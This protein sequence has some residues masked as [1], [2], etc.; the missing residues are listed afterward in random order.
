MKRKISLSTRALAFAFALVFALH[1]ANFSARAAA[2]ATSAAN[3]PFNALPASD[4]VVFIDI[5]QILTSA[6]PGLLSS[7]PALIDKMRAELNKAATESGVDPNK[8]EYAVFGVRMP[9]AGQ[10]QDPSFVALVRGSF[11]ASDVIAAGFKSAKTPVSKQEQTYQGKTI[12]IIRETKTETKSDAPKDDSDSKSGS[13]ASMMPQDMLNMKVEETALVA[14][15]SNTIAV[16]SPSLVRE[17]IDLGAGRGTRCAAAKSCSDL[18]DLATR[19]SNSV[20]GFAGNVPADMAQKMSSG[21]DPISQAAAGIRTIFGSTSYND[22]SVETRLAVRTEKSDQ[23]QTLAAGLKFLIS[24]GIGQLESSTDDNNK[25]LAALL[26]RVNVTDSAGEAQAS[27]KFTQ[28][29]IAPFLHKLAQ[30]KSSE[31]AEKTP[32]Q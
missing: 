15:D 11:N 13:A 27:I 20:V 10:R 17:T 7:E 23:A 22:G 32:Q 21:G 28:A 31:T 14:L 4:V 16:G 26:Q 3:D 8:F 30:P 2:A 12:Y 6:I 25:K 9:A 5:K 29:E 18:I 19:A 1:S 24:A